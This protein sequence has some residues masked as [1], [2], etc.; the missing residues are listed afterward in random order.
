MEKLI[1]DGFFSGTV[2]HSN[3]YIQRVKKIEEEIWRADGIQ[4][5]VESMMNALRDTSSDN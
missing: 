4:G 2:E 3:N 5:D 1:E